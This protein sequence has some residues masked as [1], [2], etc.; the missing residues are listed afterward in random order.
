MIELR[1]D[2]LFHPI[3]YYYILIDIIIMPDIILISIIK[4]HC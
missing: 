1:Y 2:L 4:K 3:L